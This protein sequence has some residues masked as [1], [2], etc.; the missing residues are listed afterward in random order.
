MVD[1]LCVSKLSGTR[2]GC[3]GGGGVERRSGTTLAPGIQLSA[4]GGTARFLERDVKP[5][6]QLHKPQFTV[7]LLINRPRVH[8]NSNAKC[9]IQKSS[10]ILE[11]HT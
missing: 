7:K 9:N 6:T 3:G 2:A 4:R 1:I 10:L 8:T 11:K 5:A